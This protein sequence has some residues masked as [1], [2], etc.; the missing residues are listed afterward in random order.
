[1]LQDYPN[2]KIYE[3]KGYYQLK[4]IVPTLPL[5]KLK[6]EELINNSVPT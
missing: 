2:Q 6:N 5:S 4:N 1:M 3:Q